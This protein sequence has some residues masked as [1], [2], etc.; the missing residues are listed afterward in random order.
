MQKFYR[1]WK[2]DLIN[3]LIVLV[4]LLIATAVA[5]D[6]FLLMMSK[7]SGESFL[8]DLFP[9]ST[10]DPKVILTQNAATVV[11]Q[12]A[13]ATA[14]VPPTM[15]T[16]PFT[17]APVT[18]T[19]TPTPIPPT[20]TAILPGFTHTPIPNETLATSIALTQTLTAVLNDDC[21]P[22]NT[23]QAGKVVDILDGTRIK[24]LIDGLV[25]T[26]QY[27]GIEPPEDKGYAQHAATINGDLVYA[28]EISLIADDTEKDTSG[29]LMR[30][31]K[32][33]DTFVNLELI[34]Q[35]FAT[36]NN[37]DTLF[38]CAEVFKLAEQSARDA[39]RGIWEIAP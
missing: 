22:N 35:G 24:V 19:F 29:P 28:K 4:V 34:Q 37:T 36:T 13:M 26:V 38:S 2:K 17:P 25:Y 32:A 33:E 18:P 7:S 20:I 12:V 10:I 15:T 14:S 5:I 1:F 11:Y 31:V 6:V 39:K 9:T 21:I 30:Y 8:E 27:L 16:I 3:K 23:V